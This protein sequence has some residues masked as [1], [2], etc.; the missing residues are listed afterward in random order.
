M[1]RQSIEKIGII[2]AG[3]MGRGIAQIAA[4]AGM[5]VHLFDTRGGASDEAIGFVGKMLDRA[6]EKGRMEAGVADAAKAR[7]HAGATMQDFAECDLVIEAIVEKLDV[8]RAVFAE[9]ESIVA[10]SAILASNTSSLSITDIAAGCRNPERVAGFHFFNPVPLMKVVEVVGGA[11]SE[12]AVV[13]RLM[14]CA[15]AMGHTPVRVKDSPGF[16]V[17]H[18]GRGFGTEALRIASEQ[19]ADF[20]TIDLVLR[21]GVGFRMGPF[22]LLDVTGLDVSHHV[23]EEVYRQFYDEQRFRPSPMTRQRLAAGL[24]GRKTGEGFYVYEGNAQQGR[25]PDYPDGDPSLI[26]S[27]HVTEARSEPARALILSALETAGVAVVADPADADLIVVMPLGNDVTTEAVNRQFDPS[28]TVGVDPISGF[29]GAPILGRV[30]VVMSNPAVRADLALAF[31]A[32][33][34]HE[35]RP[36]VLIRDSAGFIAQRVIAT[37]VNIGAE[38]AQQGIAGP[39]D[40]DTAVRLGLGYPKGPLGLADTIGASNIV[41]IL[42]RLQ[43]LTG[44]PRYRVSPWLRRRALLGMSLTEPGS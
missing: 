35:D 5:T 3:V 36:A 21:D 19:V 34:H 9:L 4:V 39:Q 10:D 41:E 40:I 14:E 27:V 22:E 18:A 6:V 31:R 8:K 43:D 2:G 30:A 13:T 25:F 33:L 15:T 16:L 26:K 44:D 29:D 38:I 37:I 1:S 7:L 42:F 23:M 24:L 28:K 20:A 12:D 11:R 17:N 32:M